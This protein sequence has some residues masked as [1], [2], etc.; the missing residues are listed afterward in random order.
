MLATPCS[1]AIVYAI[2]QLNGFIPV[3]NAWMIV[4][5]VVACGLCWLLMIS[6]SCAISKRN[7]GF[8]R[9]SPTIIKVIVGR[10]M[11]ASVVVF[12]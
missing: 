10:E 12:T 2:V 8:K 5:T 9:F 7:G 1:V 3:V 11:Q 6:V 4:E